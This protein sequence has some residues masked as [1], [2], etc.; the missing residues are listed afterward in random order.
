MVSAIAAAE[1]QSAD[2]DRLAAR[3]S[4]IAG[5]DLVAGELG[6]EIRMSNAAVR[7]VAAT[8]GRG[9]GLG[10]IDL[11]A[12]DE[13]QAAEI[14]CSIDGDTIGVCGTRIRLV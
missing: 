13:A 10:G 2:P 9:E 14:G 11:V 1:L 8:D 5:L 7:F 3:W 12:N 6:P 4:E